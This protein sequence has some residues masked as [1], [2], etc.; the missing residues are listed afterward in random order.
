MITTAEHS[1]GVSYQTSNVT[2]N[3]LRFNL[4]TME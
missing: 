4:R 1:L 2:D 3:D